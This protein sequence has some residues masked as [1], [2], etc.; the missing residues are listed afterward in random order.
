MRLSQAIKLAR[1]P[2][3]LEVHSDRQTDIVIYKIA[4]LGKIASKSLDLYPGV[5][6]I[7]GTRR[8]YR[9]V[10]QQVTVLAGQLAAP[11]EIRCSERI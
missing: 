11:I 6:T 10:R 2:V 4:E 1:I 5:Y 9:D 3:Q 7:V 8:G